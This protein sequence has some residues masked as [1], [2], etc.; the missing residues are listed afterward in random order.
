MFAFAVVVTTGCGRKAQPPREE[1]VKFPFERTRARLE[2]GRYLVEGVAECFHCHSECEWNAPGQPPTQGLKGGGQLF[3][4]AVVPFKLYC[5][6]ISPD[7]ET[8]AG[9]WTDEQFFRAVTQGVGHDGRTLF[10]LMPYMQFRKLSDEDVISMIVYVR[11][12]PAVR[13]ALPK[14]AYPEPIKQALKPLPPRPV[15]PQPDLSDPVKRGA[16]LVTVAD[17]AGCHTPVNQ[18]DVPLPGMDFAG[19]MNLKGPWGEVASANLT[20]DPSGIPYYTEAM[21]VE[22]LRT[23]YQGARK[24]NSIMPWGYFR[25][26]TDD[27]LKAVFAYLRTLKPVQHRTDNTEKF[28]QC[29]KCGNRHGLA[30][31]N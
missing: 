25:N 24:L 19:G 18:Q 12:I 7:M 20:P 10:P 23:G 8:G 6:N 29:K 5:P 21:F 30:D 11:S 1:P 9:S 26:M 3:P 17:C 27:D 13:H 2:R 14:T 31:M 15:M 22:A 28:S 4:D 16:Y